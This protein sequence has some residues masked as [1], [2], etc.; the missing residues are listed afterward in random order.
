MA[1]LLLGADGKPYTSD[2]PGQLGG[3]RKLK[4]FGKLDCPSANRFLAKG[5]YKQHRVFFAD[6]A[7]AEA[8]GYRPCAKCMPLEYS[9]WKTGQKQTK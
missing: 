4:I 5:H 2:V 8:A 1:Y 6:Q 9:A 7:T 3:H